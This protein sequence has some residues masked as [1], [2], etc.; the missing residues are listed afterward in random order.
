MLVDA[1]DEL[2]KQQPGGVSPAQQ[3][4]TLYLAGDL[5]RLADEAKKQDLSGDPTLNKKIEK[6]VIEDRN[7]NMATR[8]AAL[9]S[10]KPA[11]SYFFA[12]GALHYAGDTGILSQL[13]KKGFKITRLGPADA[14]SIVRKPAA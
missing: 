4:V 5:D 10:T 6:R 1:L 14:S 7:T 9:C 11:R 3:L 13:A 12:V 2:E 8:I